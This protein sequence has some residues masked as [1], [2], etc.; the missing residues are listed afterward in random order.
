MMFEL[1]QQQQKNV[2]RKL[3]SFK[4]ALGGFKRGCA[5]ASAFY[6]RT[7]DYL[8]DFFPFLTHTHTLWI[9]EAFI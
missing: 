2:Y 7:I 8:T 9:V 3:Q 6:R 5:R 1:E 4:N